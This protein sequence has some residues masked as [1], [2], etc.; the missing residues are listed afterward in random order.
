[1]R[2]LILLRLLAA[3]LFCSAQFP[4]EPE[5]I[6]VLRS[7]FN[8]NVTISYK[9]TFI[10]ETTPGVRGFSG[11]VH[12][13]P[14]ALAE[15]G[16]KNQTWEI[17][18]FFWFFEARKDPHNA[19]LS[20][21]YYGGPAYSSSGMPLSYNGPC[22]VN[23]DGNSTTL[24][25][26][27]WNNEVN[28]LYLDQP[29]QVGLSYST[30]H[31]VTV[32]RV[33]ETI[34]PLPE[35]S[36]VPEQNTTLLVGR[37]PANDTYKTSMGSTDAAYAMWHFAQAW[38]QEFREY[39]A[40][41][42]SLSG[43]SYAGKYAPA[44]F[45]FFEEQNER[46]R[47]GKWPTKG[48]QY[49]LPLNMLLI[50]NGLFDLPGQ[51][52]SYPEFAVDNTYGIQ[53]V[54]DTVYQTM[55]NNL[56]KPGGCLDQAYQCGNLSLQ[57]DPQAIGVNE[58]V[59]HICAEA[60]NYCDEN[61]QHLYSYSN[62]SY[63]DITVPASLSREPPFAHAFLQQPHV[64]QALGMRSNWTVR[65]DDA[66]RAFRRVGDFARP[67]WINKFGYLLDRGIKVALTYGD[68][69]YLCN[70]ISGDAA[71]LAINY[72]DTANFHA[73]GY[74]EIHTNCSYVGGLVRQYGN[75]SFSRVYQGT[76]GSA[77]LQPETA[78]QIFNRAIFGKD[79]ATGTVPADGYSS[80][81]IQD[82]RSVKNEVQTDW[83][84]IKQV[85]YLWDLHGTCT[86]EQIAMVENGTAVI[87][88]Y[89]IVDKNSTERYPEIVGL[90]D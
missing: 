10:C 21:W 36:S 12:I 31:N 84:E 13:P 28:M 23:P 33:N 14:N 67:G 61:V 3:S 55:T 19:P 32:D 7:Q 89:I 47:Q 77:E 37:Y 53:A 44:V 20:I 80:K 50:E 24:N 35:G 4:P 45:E 18:I 25:P 85:C 59:N 88:D 58:T 86:D 5:G 73:A 48:E 27:S 60:G 34:T 16:I 90:G 26:Y 17:N 63:Y 72:T 76:H 46:I 65:S 68:R 15:H 11:Y 69:D 30:F 79:I 54:N 39:Q 87:K 75:L 1:M 2:A 51:W 52:F 8:N 82:A 83:K 41:S 43:V 56:N 78:L 71:S 9:E 29:V 64:Q 42:I 40:S 6:T 66:I 49:I 81:G 70:W 22:K 62:R 57:Y 74:E 38:F